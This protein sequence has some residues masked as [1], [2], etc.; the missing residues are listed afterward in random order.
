MLERGRTHPI[1]G[2]VLLVLFV[3]L[4]VMVFLHLF[5]EGFDAL[6]GIGAT[7]IGIA[8]VL[9]L[10]GA[11][12]LRPDHS[13]KLIS[14][15]GDRAPPRASRHIALRPTRLAASLSTPLRR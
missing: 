4:L 13:L 8:V 1:L 2:P 9:G 7:C 15:P 10:L 6:A 3:L 14:K 11:S 12:R 5:H